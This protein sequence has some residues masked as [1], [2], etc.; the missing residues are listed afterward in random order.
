M[1]YL[2]SP[3][4]VVFFLLSLS[5]QAEGKK[6]KRNAEFNTQ[7]TCMKSTVALTELYMALLNQDV[8]ITEV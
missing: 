4:R 1:S 7:S 2:H 3:S 6:W 8:L 5:F